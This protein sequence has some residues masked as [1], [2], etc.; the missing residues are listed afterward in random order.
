MSRVSDFIIKDHRELEEYYHNILN[1]KTDDEKTRWQ[2][3]FT[4]ELARHSVGEEIVVYPV[5]EKVLSDGKALTDKD[6]KEHQVVK[7]ELFKFQKMEASDP[8]FEPT[9]RELWS[10]LI[11]HMREE[12]EIDLVKLEH[13]L[14]AEESADLGKSFHRTKKFVPTRSHPSAPD[15]PP[16]ETVVGLLTAPIDKLRDVFTRFPIK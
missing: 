5:M 3:Q 16:F 10:N 13:A 2:N 11:Q 15:Q 6:R 4:W 8:E 1:S 14:S 9:L 7:E 12:E